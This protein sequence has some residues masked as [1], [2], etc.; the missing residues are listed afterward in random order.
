MIPHERSLV[1]KMKDKPFALLGVN[2]DKDKDYFHAEAA[3]MGVTWRSFW[4]G[5]K[6]TSGPIPSKWNVRGWPT[7][8]VIDH[9]GVIRHKWVGSPGNEVL[10]EA[11]AT[12]VEQAEKDAKK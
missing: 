2:S 8:Y 5:D 10:D 3:D 6:G 7:L 1:E 9:E 12:L 11:I 4:C